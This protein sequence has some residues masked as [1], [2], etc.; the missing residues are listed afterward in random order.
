[1][2]QRKTGVRGEISRRAFLQGSALAGFG[3]FL[4]ACTGGA[5]SPSAPASIAVPTPPPVSPS[6][7]VAPSPT[8]K[9]IPTGPLEW[10]TWEAY[11]DLV[12]KAAEAQKY[13]PGSSPTIVQFKKKYSVDVDYV[14]K[15]NDNEEFFATLQAPFVSGLPT[16]WDLI[17]MT[18]WMAA[19]LISKGW[20]E[21]IDQS[22]VP[23]CVANLRDALRNQPWDA[24]NDFHYPWQSGMTGI[25]FN[26]KT[27][28]A[29]NKPEPKSLKDLYALPANKITFL[30]ESRDTFGLGLLKLGKSADPAQ[31]T[32][33]DLQ[34]VHDDI[35]PL[36]EKGLRFT[37]NDYLQDFAAKKVYAAMVWSGDLASSGTEGDTFVFPEEGVMVWTDN[38]MIPKGAKNKYTAE[39]MMNFVYDPKIAAQI[40]NYV[41]YVCPVNGAEDILKALNKSAPLDSYHLN[42]LFPPADIVAKQ[43]N[44]QFLTPDLDK[45]L[46]ELFLDLQG[47]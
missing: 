1:M 44:F 30:T 26:T 10:A 9:P 2:D 37:G 12:G 4:A 47:K 19:Q 13:A 8:P 15:I 16:G 39:L 25:G 11:I 14:E 6:P 17:V 36:T 23:N 35:K 46:K 18:D 27:L 21:Q 41:Y 29:V 34:A 28:K 38:M 5:Q 31:T 43:H 20:I 45:S 3:A 33:D 7:S 32:A 24:K 40:E 22:N 42:L